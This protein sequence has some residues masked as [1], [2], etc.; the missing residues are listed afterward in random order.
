M[1]KTILFFLMILTFSLFA[2]KLYWVNVSGMI[3][4]G[5]S[6]YIER[7]I[8]SAKTDEADFIIFEINTFGGRVDSATEIKDNIMNS[9]IPT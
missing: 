2:E 5:V 7:S 8:E 1:K 4:N 3:D 6:S 9:T